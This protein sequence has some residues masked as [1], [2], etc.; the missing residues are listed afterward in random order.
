MTFSVSIIGSFRQHYEGIVLSVK[1][2]ESLGVTVNSPAISKIIN[3]GARYV[4][5]QINSPQSSDQHI[6]AAT[7]DKILG[8][9]LVYVVARLDM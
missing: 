4:R 6:Q 8:S 7:L 2:F 5:F 1:E 9:D 3:P